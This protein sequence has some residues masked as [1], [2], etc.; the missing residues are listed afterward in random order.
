[1]DGVPSGQPPGAGELPLPGTA[2]VRPPDSQWWTG[3]QFAAL[4]TGFDEPML[5]RLGDKMLN[6]ATGAPWI[7][8]PRA[9]KF[10]FLPTL[11]GVLA[12]LLHQLVTRPAPGG[13]VIPEYFDSMQHMADSGL[14]VPKKFI[15]WALENGAGAAR[16]LQPQLI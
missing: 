2:G 16:Q 3:A 11:K 13:V 7:P 12:Y 6:P 4:V 14:G 15:G 5:R 10:E 1:M 9:A 8:K